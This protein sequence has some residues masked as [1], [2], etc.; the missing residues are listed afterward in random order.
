MFRANDPSTLAL[1]QDH[2]NDCFSNTA[3]LICAFAAQKW[4]IYLD[5]IGAIAVALY[6]ATTWF[7]TGREQLV[8]LSGKSAEPDFINRIIKVS[9]FIYFLCLDISINNVFIGMHRP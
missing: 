1:A 8:R 6:I 4:W 2:K 9:I 7:F 3:A 5:P